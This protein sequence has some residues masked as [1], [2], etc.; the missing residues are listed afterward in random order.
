MAQKTTKFTNSR[1]VRE[2]TVTLDFTDSIP[3]KLFRLPAGSRL[4]DYVINVKTPFSGGA[5]QE[6]DV[7]V[8][9]DPDAIL[10]GVSLAAAGRAAIT[11]ELVQPGYETAE[12]TDIYAQIN[13]SGNTAGEVD[14][15]CI[16]SVIKLTRM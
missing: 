4:I 6:L 2:M 15:T 7:G 8:K 3:T 16:F 13:D 9:G 5:A 11:T 10:D 1:E 14:L 12:Q